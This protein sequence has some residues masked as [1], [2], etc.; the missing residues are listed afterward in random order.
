VTITGI[1]LSWITGADDGYKANNGDI[2]LTGEAIDITTHISTE[3]FYVGDRWTTENPG[4][5]VYIGMSDF[6]YVNLPT[7]NLLT[8]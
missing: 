1:V 7:S 3:T 4:L 6:D 2:T 5:Q 8:R